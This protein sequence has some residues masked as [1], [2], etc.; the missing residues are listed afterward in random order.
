ML[1]VKES[2]RQLYFISKRSAFES[3]CQVK[4]PRVKTSN[5]FFC[6]CQIFSTWIS[7]MQKCAVFV[8]CLA[9]FSVFFSAPEA[10]PG[11]QQRLG[12]LRVSRDWTVA[13]LNSSLTTKYSLTRFSTVSTELAT[14]NGKALSALPLLQ[15][16]GLI[17]FCVPSS[18]VQLQKEF[19]ATSTDQ[20]IDKIKIIHF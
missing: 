3:M 11:Q 7:R 4:C 8:D 17:I 6:T 19:K 1:W 5:L 10:G 13:R 18:Q 15:D 2:I 12:A 16:L 9:T 20:K 14:L